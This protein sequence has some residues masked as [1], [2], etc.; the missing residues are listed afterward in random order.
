MQKWSKLIVVLTMALLTP[1]VVASAQNNPGNSKLEQEIREAINT[2]HE[3]F[4]RGDREGWGA[5]VADKGVFVE[6]GNVITKAQFKAGLHPAIGLKQSIEISDLS[7]QDFGAVVVATFRQ[8][9][10]QQYG[11]QALN[12]YQ[13]MVETYQKK[14]DRWVLLAQGAVADPVRHKATS[15]DSAT[16]DTYV[17][18]YAWSPGYVETITREGNK[19]MISFPGEDGKVEFFPESATTFFLANDAEDGLTTF[20]KDA[21]GKVT[22]YVVRQQGQEVIGKKIK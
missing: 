16:L 8:V 17:G 14:G 5:H 13:H 1:C 9:L 21:S 4:L 11:D 19:L 18:E 6:P 15:V 12:V 3:F 7:V 22:H 10:K 20:V 2:R